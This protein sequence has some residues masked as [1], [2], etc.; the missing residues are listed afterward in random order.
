MPSPDRWRL[1]SN[2]RYSHPQIPW[3]VSTTAALLFG[4]GVLVEDYGS[5]TVFGFTTSGVH[6]VTENYKIKRLDCVANLVPATAVEIPGTA[7]N[8]FDVLSA[9]YP[10]PGWSYASSV[11]P[12]TAGSLAVKT[13]DVQGTPARVGAEFHVKYMPGA[14]DPVG[15][16]WIQVVTNNHRIGAGG[17]HGIADNK[18]DVD[19]GQADPYY[20]NGGAADATDFYDFPGRVDTCRDHTWNADLYVVE[21]PAIGAGPGLITLHHPGVRWGWE[22]TCVDQPDDGGYSCVTATPVTF[23]TEIP[24]APG[25]VIETVALTPASLNLMKGPLNA[26][27]SLQSAHLSISISPVIDAGGISSYT[28]TGGGGQFAPYVF[29]NQ[30]VGISTFTVVNGNGAIHWEA[31][32]MSAHMILRVSAAGF[33]DIIAVADGSGHIGGAGMSVT[34]DPDSMGVELVGGAIPTISGWG[35]I[36]LTLL[37]LTVGVVLQ[38]HRAKSGGAAR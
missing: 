7:G 33:A 21:G 35:T 12:L 29:G 10:G 27:V 26:V 5:E 8:F 24:F 22:N 31:N 34:I 4:S 28:I 13:Y 32:E 18:V 30:P 25:A 14:G 23:A 15:I 19:A 36:V 3:S 2:E 37:L 9:S 16:H 6:D 1:K 17:G 38:K 11:I 20:D